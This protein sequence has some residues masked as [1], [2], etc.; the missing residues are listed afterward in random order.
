MIAAE[1]ET[2][3]LEVGIRWVGKHHPELYEYVREAVVD[4]CSPT[5]R[6]GWGRSLVAYAVLSPG[7]EARYGLHRYRFWRRRIWWL[8]P[9]DPYEGGGAPYEAVVAVSIRP[10]RPSAPIGWTRPTTRR[11]TRGHAEDTKGRRGDA[12]ADTGK[13]RPTW[14]MEGS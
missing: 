1:M 4:H 3:R 13:T 2:L 11:R 10:G 7:A 14:P 5:S 9:H 12:T 6:P 8:A